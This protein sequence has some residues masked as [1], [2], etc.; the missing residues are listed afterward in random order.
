MSGGNRELLITRRLIPKDGE[1]AEGK[2]KG[3]SAHTIAA[4]DCF[5]ASAPHGSVREKER[6][7]ARTRARRVVVQPAIQPAIQATD[8]PTDRPGGGAEALGMP[9]A[10]EPPRG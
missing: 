10:S 3:V 8:R 1:R 7:R 2:G 5:G 4:A 9:V 6:K